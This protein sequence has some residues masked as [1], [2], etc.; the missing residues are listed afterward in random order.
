MA[1]G[2]LRGSGLRSN[3]AFGDSRRHPHSARF[4]NCPVELL[5]EYPGDASPMSLLGRMHDG[6]VHNRRVD[7]LSDHLAELIPP[8]A[9]VLDVGCGD[10]LLARRI[11]QKRSDIE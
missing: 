11:M 1:S 10:G 9:R 6:Y 8:H 2:G 3:H 4:P 5:R 7:V